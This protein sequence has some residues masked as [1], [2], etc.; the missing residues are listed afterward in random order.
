MYVAPESN[1]KPLHFASHAASSQQSASQPASQPCSQ[2][3][4]QPATSQLSSS[5]TTM[6]HRAPALCRSCRCRRGHPAGQRYKSC[7]AGEALWRRFRPGTIGRPNWPV[8]WASSTAWAE[9]GLDASRAAKYDAA[10]IKAAYFEKARACHPDLHGGDLANTRRFQVLSCAVTEVLTAHAA[11][12]QDSA[13]TD[14][15]VENIDDSN[16][17]HFARSVFDLFQGEINEQTRAEVRELGAMSQGGP[18]KGGWWAFAQMAAA[19]ADIETQPTQ[20]RSESSKL[21]SGKVGQWKRARR[22]KRS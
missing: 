15:S 5:T 11:I 9:L 8:R 2:P 7:W 13:S 20:N 4:S 3:A 17:D 10:D 6:L 1:A 18:D 19:E 16:P 21:R 12:A 14:V 22:R